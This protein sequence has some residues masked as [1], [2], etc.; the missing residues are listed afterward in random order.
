MR[1]NR[2]TVYKVKKPENDNRKYRGE[3]KIYHPDGTSQ[4]CYSSGRSKREAREKL[5]QATAR[6]RRKYSISSQQSLSDVFKSLIVE[7]K[8]AKLKAKSIYN[9]ERLFNKHLIHLADKPITLISYTDLRDTLAGIQQQGF[10]RTAELTRILLNELF[11]H[12]LKIN[13]QKIAAGHFTLI[14]HAQDLPVVKKTKSKT[15]NTYIW[16]EKERLAFLAESKKRYEA[17]L[18]SMSHPVFVLMLSAG[19]RL[20]EALGMKKDSH[21]QNAVSVTEQ[22]VYYDSKHHEETPKTEASLRVIP[23]SNEVSDLLDAHKMKII[24]VS[25][26]SPGWSNFDLLLPSFSG[27][28]FVPRNL[29]RSKTEICEKIGIPDIDLHTLR[30]IYCTLLTKE[31]VKQGTWSPKI[32]MQLMG[33]N[34]PL[35]AQQVYAQVVEEDKDKAIVN[36][37]I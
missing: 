21:T 18:R 8:L 22:F 11:K 32:V 16:T 29:R 26:L 2:G 33:H 19:L 28:P 1:Q 5:D 12:A 9:N 27:R 23:V 35:V 4:N 31:L 20:G 6:A 10:D 13:K 15:S 17:S 34:N 14:N 24:E 7:K 30:K 37:G 36:I 3:V 25:Q